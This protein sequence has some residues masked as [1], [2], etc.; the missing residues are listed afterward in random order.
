MPLSP[1]HVRAEIAFRV[2]HAA[3]RKARTLIKSR[4]LRDAME[5]K[6]EHATS[7]TTFGI[8]HIPHYWAVYYHD[9][10]RGFGPD[11][12]KRLVF[13]RNPSRD[14][15]IAGGHPIRA[16]QIR[17]LNLSKEAFKAAK[18]GNEIHVRRHVGP[19]AGHHFFTRGMRSFS[20]KVG[21]IA[22][23]ILADWI[24]DG[25][26]EDGA[27]DVEETATGTIRVGL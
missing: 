23:P 5:V 6:V 14:P 27:L 9:G 11:R 18:E 12:A 4:T 8:V 25:L 13:F 3:M 26:R 22:R 15:R 16:S 19:A 20:R 2:A 7:N 17:R 24:L 21:P 1:L 10:R